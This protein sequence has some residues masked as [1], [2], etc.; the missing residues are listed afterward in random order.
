MT[1]QLISQYLDAVMQ[2]DAAVVKDF[3][4]S[5]PDLMEAEDKY[6][7]SAMKVAVL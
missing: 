2:G 1:S 7:D 3:I 5:Y 4:K 6:G